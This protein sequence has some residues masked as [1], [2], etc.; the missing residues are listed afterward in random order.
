[1]P[2]QPLT[3]NQYIQSMIQL[4]CY[5]ETGYIWKM[6]G[7]FL[8]YGE[9][10]EHLYTLREDVDT[11]CMSTFEFVKVE[12]VRTQHLAKIDIQPKNPSSFIHGTIEND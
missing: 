8:T 4:W 12:V 5:Y 3:E 1:M 2:E 7:F 11:P 6:E 9:A 10:K